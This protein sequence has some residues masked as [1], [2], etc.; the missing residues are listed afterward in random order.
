MSSIKE[1]NFWKAIK[2]EVGLDDLRIY[3]I[4]KIDDV[5]LEMN[6]KKKLWKR[7]VIF[8]VAFTS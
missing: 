1:I 5:V 2:P 8:F 7:K 4:K 6:S 3:K